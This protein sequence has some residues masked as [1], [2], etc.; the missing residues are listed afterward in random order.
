VANLSGKILYKL[1]GICF[2]LAVGCTYLAFR[3]T[4]NGL[5]VS[6]ILESGVTERSEVKA[7][8]A[9][10]GEFLVLVPR[11]IPT[12]AAHPAKIFN[13]AEAARGCWI[14]D[15]ST[16]HDPCLLTFLGHGCRSVARTFSTCRRHDNYL[17]LPSDALFL[18]TLERGDSGSSG[19]VPWHVV[20]GKMGPCPGQSGGLRGN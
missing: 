20:G 12:T 14:C 19:I 16:G 15:S 1:R 13:V 9:H 17:G 4:K 18:E 6:T 2:L 11:Q 7:V 3:M 10:A 5:L 8:W